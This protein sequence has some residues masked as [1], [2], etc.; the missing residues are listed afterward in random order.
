MNKCSNTMPEDG[1]AGTAAGVGTEA[2]KVW[3]ERMPEEGTWEACAMRPQM[4]A[5]GEPAWSERV[6]ELGLLEVGVARTR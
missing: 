6:L 4:I 5:E 1:R 2:L 3:V